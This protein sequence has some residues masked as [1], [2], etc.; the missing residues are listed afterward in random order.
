VKPGRYMSGS[1]PFDVADRVVTLG[2]FQRQPITLPM[3]V[4]NIA[5]NRKVRTLNFLHAGPDNMWKV[6]YWRYV[7]HYADGQTVE[8][9]PTRPEFLCY[10]ENF[11]AA[12]ALLNPAVSV[13]GV[14]GIGTVYQWVNPR[15]DAEVRAVDFRTM[16]LGQAV[17]VGFTA[18]Y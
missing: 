7:V 6:E 12:G 3:A 10:K 18:G 8:V 17:L 9:V 16:D 2:C 13:G 14:S 4:N 15:P 1:I 5:V 11:F